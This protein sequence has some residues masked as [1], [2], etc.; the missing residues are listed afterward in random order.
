MNLIFY[1]IIAMSVYASIV[2]IIILII[3]KV[4]KKIPITFLNL[5][6]IFVLI[7]LII[8]INI[9]SKISIQ[10]YI[11][12]I[13]SDFV[14]VNE[15]N[16]DENNVILQK[17]A[18]QTKLNIF[19]I[20]VFS[21]FSISLFL[22]SKDMYFYVLLKKKITTNANPQENICNI[23]C[24]CKERLKI[25]SK[26]NTIIQKEIKTPALLGVANPTLLLTEEIQNLS[27]KELEYIFIHELVHY[28][29]L[30]TIWYFI[31]NIIKNIY[32]FNPIVI[33]IISKIKEDIEYIA[34]KITVDIL[35]DYKSYCKVLLKVVQSNIEKNNT[36]VA[37][38]QNKKSLERRIKMLKNKTVISFSTI[39]IFILLITGVFFIS[40]TLATNKLEDKIE[41]KIITQ[42]KAQE[43]VFPLHG[44]YKVSNNY[45]TRIHPITKHEM[46]HNGVDL[47]T[48]QGESVFAIS[49]GIVIKA[50][51]D[52]EKG[53]YIEIKHGDL[54]SEYRHLSQIYVSVGDEVTAGEKIGEVGATGKATGP[55]LHLGIIN[56]NNE[57]INPM[58]YIEL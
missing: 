8:P 50:S 24:S 48:N 3:K 9:K 54:T 32:W 55:H 37:I 56:E 27:T 34:D 22:I 58:D 13:T 35:S 45:G 31:L 30:D 1:K 52:N 19:D 17:N 2:G 14:S 21:W 23:F 53:N 44:E 57:Y 7:L 18:V 36:V 12:E 11:P 47:A 15:W 41:N 16:I 25:K 29:K 39:C 43:Y 42:T 33:Y 28:K 20:V 51:F 26:I 5:L 10:N 38:C 49:N 40:A 46:S 4:F 6:W